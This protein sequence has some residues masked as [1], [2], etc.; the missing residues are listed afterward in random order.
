MNR[1][2]QA[3]PTGPA[4]ARPSRG[5]NALVVVLAAAALTGIGAGVAAAESTP[6]STARSD[7]YT[8]EAFREH[9]KPFDSISIPSLRCFDGGP[10]SGDGRPG[11][12]ENKDYSPGRGVPRGVE[13]IE[14]GG[15]GVTITHPKY[16]PMDPTGSFWPTTGTDG[17]RGWSNATNWDPFTGRELVIK[18]HCTYDINQ[19]ATKTFIP[20]FPTP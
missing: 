17:H 5:A 6:T 3:D 12:L 18:L 14:P 16:G 4:Q 11:M 19:A 7:N 15:I 9:I 8:F 1:R 13:V 2:I 20:G 10:G